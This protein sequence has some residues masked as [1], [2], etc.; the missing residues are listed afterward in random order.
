MFTANNHIDPLI[1]ID[2]DL[3]TLYKIAENFKTSNEYNKKYY[4]CSDKKYLQ[5][6]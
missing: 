6:S 2:S 5:K 3:N 1:N 4:L